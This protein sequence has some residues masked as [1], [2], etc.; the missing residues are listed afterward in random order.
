MG[1]GGGV[2]SHY[3]Q[4]NKTTLADDFPTEAVE[5]RKP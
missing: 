5:T 2:K 3:L 1:E 4:R